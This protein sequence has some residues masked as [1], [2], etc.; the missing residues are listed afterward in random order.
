MQYANWDALIGLLNSQK[1]WQVGFVFHGCV[2]TG[3]GDSILLL[4][5]SADARAHMQTTLT[6]TNAEMKDQI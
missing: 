2:M 5:A 3:H 1:N 6:L 4:A